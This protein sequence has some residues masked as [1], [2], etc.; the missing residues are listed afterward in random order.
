M[1]S[2]IVALLFC[3]LTGLAWGQNNDE[4]EY[5]ENYEF[6][7]TRDVLVNIGLGFGIDY[8]LFGGRLSFVPVKHLSI[9]AAVGY[10]FNGP[11]YNGGV[12]VRILPDKKVCPYLGLI[13]GFNTVYLSGNSGQSKTYNG[14]TI[15]SGIELHRK[16]KPNFWNFGLNVPI[17]SQEFRDDE[18]VYKQDPDYIAPSPI[19][20]TVGFHFGL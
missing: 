9:S 1:K 18:D 15:T 8:G 6:P 20:I 11:G 16:N 7:E 12:S 4:S 17:R 3:L 19:G 10:T 13:Y 5:D 14:F 2:G